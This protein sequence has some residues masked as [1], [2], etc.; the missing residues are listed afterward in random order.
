[1]IRKDIEKHL[2]T[3]QKPCRYTGG[4]PGSIIKGKNGVRIRFA[5]CFPDTYEIGMSHLG[6]KILYG[7]YNSQ[8]DVW[9]ERAFAPA[10]DMEAVMRRENIPLYGLESGDDI[11][12]FDFVGFTLQYELCYSTMLNMLDLA[13]IPLLASG[14]DETHPLV[15]AGG[16]CACNPEPL[17][18]F[19]D[20]FVLGEGEEVSLELF[21]LYRRMKSSDGFC[22]ETFLRESAGIEGVYV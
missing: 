3:V 8:P 2:L 20:L 1:M 17:C 11:K 22:K 9:C 7:L 19:V 4:E 6:M 10:A 12:S 18:D 15:I 21:G 5:F 13:D 16:P 14:R